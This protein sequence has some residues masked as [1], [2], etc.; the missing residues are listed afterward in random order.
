MFFFDV[1]IYRKSMKKSAIENLSNLMEKRKRLYWFRL[2]N[3]NSTL[4][5]TDVLKSAIKTEDGNVQ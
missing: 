1:E 5:C 2:S 4:F 3:E